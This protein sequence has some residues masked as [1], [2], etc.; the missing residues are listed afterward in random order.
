M[1]TTHAN[2]RCSIFTQNHIHI[3]NKHVNYT[4]LHIFFSTLLFWMTA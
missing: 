1:L 4:S 2:V 3:N